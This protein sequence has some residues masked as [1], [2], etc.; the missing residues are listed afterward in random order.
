[1]EG[2]DEPPTPEQSRLLEALAG[3]AALAIERTNLVGD[4]E[5]ANLAAETDRLRSAVLSS[6]SN[7]L[8]TPIASIVAATD[9]LI[10]ADA[11]GMPEAE[12]QGCGAVDSGGGGA[13]RPF[14][15]EP[16]R[17]DP[18]GDG[19]VC[20]HGPT[21][22]NST[23]IVA[24][25]LDRAKKLLKERRM[26]I[27]IDPALPRLR[28]DRVLMEQVFF[29]L[30]DNACKYSPPDSRIVI[31]AR[32]QGDRLLIEIS[33]EG[34]GIPPEDREKVFDMFSGPRGA[35]AS[36]A[37]ALPCVAA[38]SKRTMAASAIESG[39]NDV[40]TSV[41]IQLPCRRRS[42]R[43][44]LAKERIDLPQPKRGRSFRSSALRQ[45]LVGWRMTI[46]ATTAPTAARYRPTFSRMRWPI[47]GCGGG[48]RKRSPVIVSYSA[49]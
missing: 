3:Q 24:E 18:A 33:D 47:G 48:G 30:I 19:R 44:S 10:E 12:R 7:E 41:C 8:K 35:P 40:G 31:W 23:T 6:L 42:L 5:A 26:Q 27:D 17:H 9:R 37:S 13:A 16:A 49:M 34:P 21:G 25:V 20:G 1:M 43:R 11:A 39:L 36:T 32:R 4:V 29:N 45:R 14:R 22:R 46:R 28:V 2:D 38:S 15:P